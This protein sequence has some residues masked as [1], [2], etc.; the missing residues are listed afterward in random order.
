MPGVS[1]QGTAKVSTFE[2]L[3]LFTETP[4]DPPK[5]N[6]GPPAQLHSAE[7]VEAAAAIRTKLPK[8]RLVV[9]EI[10]EGAGPLTDEQIAAMTGLSPNTARPRRIE[11]V[12][13]GLVVKAGVV[14]NAKGRSAAL[15]AVNERAIA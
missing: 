14:K 9:L 4:V 1:G 10:I 2:Y 13:D 11:L 5:L 3:D 6:N 8:L 7:S 12:N 15:W